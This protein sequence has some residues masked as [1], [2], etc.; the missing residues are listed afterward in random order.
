MGKV[1]RG[2]ACAGAVAAGAVGACLHVARV[3]AVAVGACLHVGAADVPATCLC[4]ARV[5]AVADQAA[6][7]RPRAARSVAVRSHVLLVTC[8][9]QNHFAPEYVK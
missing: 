5:G 2:A 1:L 7:F 8:C 9:F 3:R 4:V 6:C